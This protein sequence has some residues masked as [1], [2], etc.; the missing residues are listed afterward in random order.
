MDAPTLQQAITLISAYDTES[1]IMFRQSILNGLLD[2]IKSVTKCDDGSSEN[3]AL[4]VVLIPLVCIESLIKFLIAIFLLF[5]YGLVIRWLVARELCRQLFRARIEDFP[6][7]F[8]RA[9]NG[10]GRVF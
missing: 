6:G 9:P 10:V 4:V 8:E 1:L 2:H 3:L 5:I 7:G